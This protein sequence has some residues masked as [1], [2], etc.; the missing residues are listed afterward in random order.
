MNLMSQYFLTINFLNA[1]AAGSAYK[2]TKEDC[3]WI[4]PT[5]QHCRQW[6]S[7]L[8]EANTHDAVT[9]VLSSH[10]PTLMK[11]WT[12]L[13]PALTNPSQMFAFIF[14]IPSQ[15]IENIQS[16]N[17]V[18]EYH[19]AP[20]ES[21]PPPCSLS[22]QSYRS[23]KNGNGRWLFHIHHFQVPNPEISLESINFTRTHL[24]IRMTST[25]HLFTTLYPRILGWRLSSTVS[26]PAWTVSAPI[27]RYWP[28]QETSWLRLAEH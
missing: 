9:M 3:P 5:E 17:N 13:G 25:L 14:S 16:I 21:V 12:C 2:K 7:M 1:S 4:F 8:A 18:V 20:S 11:W 23:G 22:R 19:G 15:R 10:L 24:L 28:C 27:E 6:S 26:W